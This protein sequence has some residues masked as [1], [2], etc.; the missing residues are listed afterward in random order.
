MAL[1]QDPYGFIFVVDTLNN[2]IQKFDK[3]FDFVGKWGSV[4]K[5]SGQL[6]DPAG[7]CLTWEPDWAPKDE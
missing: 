4:G 3:E 7:I 2:R 6:R 1:A 5:E